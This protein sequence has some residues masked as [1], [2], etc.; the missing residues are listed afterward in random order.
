MLFSYTANPPQSP[1]SRGDGD[2]LRAEAR[3]TGT[4]PGPIGGCPGFAGCSDNSCKKPETQTLAAGHH[5][6][7]KPV[8]LGQ[9]PIR[10]GT[11]PSLLPAVVKND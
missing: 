11:V 8:N 5:G 2:S 9:P 6:Y 7:I 4:V 3:K 10:P 1:F